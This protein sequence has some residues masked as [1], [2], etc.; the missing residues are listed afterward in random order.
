MASRRRKA[1]VGAAVVT[2]AL[3]SVL[4]GVGDAEP[5]RPA[6]Q[7]PTP[8][9]TR[10]APTSAS[11]TTA[12]ASTTTVAPIITAAP[13][14][15]VAPT[16]SPP[17]NATTTPPPTN[18]PLAT[19][20]IRSTA[21]LPWFDPSASWNRPVSDFGPSAVHQQY[22]QR[23]WDFGGGEAPAGTINVA[24]GDY[25]VPVYPLSEATTT[26]RAYQTSWAMELYGFGVPL[27]TKIPWNP[28]WRPGT[29]NDNILAI[30]DEQTGRVWEIGG[31][32]QLNVNCANRAN[33]AAAEQNRDFS[34]TYL[35]VG[36]VRIY[37][38]LFTATDATTV[39]GRGAGI[40]KLALLTRADE[41]K[42][43]AI[44]HALQMTVTASMF[45]PACSPGR[46]AS[47]P[48]AGV[49]CGFFL[50]PATKLE[51]INPDVGCPTSQT[52]TDAERSKTVPEGMRFALRVS[53]DE[54]A[55]WL[56]SRGYS[57]RIRE[58]ARIFAVALRDYGWIVAETGCWGMHIETDSVIGASG[59]SWADVGIVSNGSAYPRGDLLNG[60]FR[61]ERIYVVEPPG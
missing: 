15:T 39:D 2:A 40:N 17:P 45:G 4:I 22:A 59:Q 19:A 5:E 51:R 1:V 27:G 61:P 33:V 3:C 29:G 46:G 42:A 24:F 55:R 49:S 48:G 57:G 30:V 10:S 14:D 21:R 20:T 18:A 43:G 60:L 58:T 54:I 11:T 35:C 50:P 32:G 52:V 12:A 16:T 25:S 47:A 41:V 23:L 7:R 36:G 56:D 38:N 28:A 44:R 34:S 13:V 8:S 37:D 26:A 9:T 31:V 6:S 53:D